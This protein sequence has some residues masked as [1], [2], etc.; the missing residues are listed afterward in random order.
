MR[1]IFT[2]LSGILAI[3]VLLVTWITV[4]NKRPIDINAN[5]ETR[6]ATYVA[7]TIL[8]P[9]G[10]RFSILPTALAAA[11]EGALFEG[12]SWFKSRPLAHSSVFI[13]HP[14]GFLMFDTGLGRAIDSQFSAFPAVTKLMVAYETLKPAVDIIQADNP[15]PGRKISIIPSHLHWDHAGGIE[16][17]PSAEV[18]VRQS[19]LEY[20]DLGGLHDGYLPSQIDSNLIK[21]R[22]LVFTDESHEQYRQ[23]LDFFGDGSVVLVPMKGHTHGAVGLFL[24]M[25]QQ[26]YL[27]TGDTTWAREA[28]EVPAHKFFLMRSMVDWNLDDLEREIV[29]IN[30]LMDRDKGLV[31]IPAHDLE[32]YPQRAVYPEWIKNVD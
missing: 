13:C 12:G 8:A 10:L 26:K 6:D 11:P 29:G 21:W 22:D 28:F 14:Q 18:W 5:I 27:F 23:S 4:F 2:V 19:E 32:A 25:G 17:F 3:L 9:H 30:L 20:A 15:C 31:V 7:K 1:N 16:D 24:N